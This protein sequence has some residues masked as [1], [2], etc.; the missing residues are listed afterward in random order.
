MGN[1]SGNMRKVRAGRR[2]A[3]RVSLSAILIALGVVLSVFPGSFYIGG[4][5]EFPFQ[6]MINAISGVL[7]GPF[8]GAFIAL[9]IGVFRISLG[10]GTVFALTGGIPGA[11]VVGVVYRYVWR[12]YG[13]A[14]AEPIGTV[15]GALLSAFLVAPTI[16][17]NMPAI[18]GLTSQWLL[19]VIY[20]LIA[21]IPGAI[22]GYI[23]LKILKRSGMIERLQI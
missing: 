5:K 17:A 13:A 8:Y 9:A 21:S 22:L 11:I 6:H 2:A 15:T 7:L 16:G 4:A 20:F 18:G 1:S 23:V 12:R 14:L 10:T 19:F 3:V